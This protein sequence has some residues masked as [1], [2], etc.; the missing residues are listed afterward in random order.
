VRAASWNGAGLFFSGEDCG[1]QLEA[2]AGRSAVQAMV[3]GRE[4]EILVGQHECG[5][6]MQ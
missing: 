4:Q 5:G 6:K 3:P 2:L 1:K